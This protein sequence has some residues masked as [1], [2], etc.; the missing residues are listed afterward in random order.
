MKNLNLSEIFIYPVKSM[1]GISVKSAKVTERGLQNDRRWLLVDE[2]NIF[3]TQRTLP[4]MALISISI[5]DGFIQ[6]KHK[7]KDIEP[8]FF[9]Q[10]VNEGKEI[11]VQIWKDN[12]TALHYNNTLDKWLSN[13]LKINCKLIF[14]PDLTKREVDKS[15]AFNNELVSFADGFPFSLIGQSSLDDLNG[16][17]KKHVPITRF[18]PNFVF[19]GGEPFEEEIGRASCRERV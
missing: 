17:L 7:T 14:M 12:C 3:I 10:E 5:N 13:V 2:K 19:A 9:P 11:K 15:Y 1:S 16:R 6:L 18:R 8:I 4:E